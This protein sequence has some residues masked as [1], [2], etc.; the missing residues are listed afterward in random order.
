MLAKS[1]PER[2]FLMADEAPANVSVLPGRADVDSELLTRIAGDRDR[3]ALDAI[4]RHYGPRLKAWLMRRGEQE[5]TA[6]DIV[7][8]VMVTIWIKAKL[9]DPDRGSFSTWAYRLTRNCW[10]DQKRKHKRMEPTDFNAITRLADGAAPAADADYDRREAF[11]AVHQEL[12]VLSPEQKQILHLSFFEGLSHSEIAQRTGLPLGTVK[13]RIR[14][15]LKKMKDRLQ[16]YSEFSH[17]E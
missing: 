2:K 1:V 17:D 6:E 14:A 15:P 11:R 7:Q 13:S 9:F 5:S 3:S 4:A 12:A 8:D 16:E 10:I